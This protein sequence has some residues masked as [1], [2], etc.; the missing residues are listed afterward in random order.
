MRQNIKIVTGWIHASLI[1]AL[2]LPTFYTFRTDRE[3]Q[4]EA[5]IFFICLSTIIPIISTSVAIKKCRNIGQYLFICIIILAVT[6]VLVTVFGNALSY[7]GTTQ[8]CVIVILAISL[9]V[10]WARIKGRMD[11]KDRLESKKR[12]DI[13]WKPASG[14]LEKPTIYMLVYF[15]V[16]YGIG[17]K[18]A[19]VRLCNE[20]LVCAFIYLLAAMVRQYIDSTESYLSLN[21]R[22]CNLPGKRIYGIGGIVFAGVMLM[23]VLVSIPAF[24]TTSYRRYMNF[25]GFSI[26]KEVYFE[27][28]AFNDDQ[29]MDPSSYGVPEVN[30]T[31]QK[32]F[33][34]L[35][36][37]FYVLGAIFVIFFAVIIIKSLRG[38]VRRFREAQDENGDLVEPLDTVEDIEKIKTKMRRTSR[39]ENT[40][41]EKI[42][43]EYR[44]TIRKY[45]REIPNPA[46][47][48]YEIE[49]NAGIEQ[50]KDMQELHESYEA[51][52]YGSTQE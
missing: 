13:D 2:I 4:V 22:V 1:L 45:R 18:T 19:S 42:R 40:E 9:Y 31:A 14:I 36:R 26:E 6:G 28:D 43:R 33:I 12:Q 44:K 35:E 34:V 41:R 27:E 37:I 51:A 10:M 15:T 47:T 30:K 52:R 38:A 25:H 11:Q 21:R 3:A 5:T 29:L 49:T 24:L 16:I 7:E 23:L 46:E 32:A 48:P 39:R 50:N 17:I 20:A 8:I